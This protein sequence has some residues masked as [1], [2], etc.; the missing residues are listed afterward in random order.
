MDTLLEGAEKLSIPALILIVLGYI[1]VNW[2]NNYKT[3]K[4]AHDAMECEKLKANL[5]LLEESYRV[6]KTKM[7]AM[8]IAFSLLYE[9]TAFEHRDTPEKIMRWQQLKKI[10]DE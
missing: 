6:Q 8:S 2:I 10:M 1:V 4:I 5:K 9:Q 3:K 7:T